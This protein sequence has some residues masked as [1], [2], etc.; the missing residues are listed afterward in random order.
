MGP[1]RGQPL[2]RAGNG[3]VAG[4]RWERSGGGDGVGEGRKEQP[5]PPR[6]PQALEERKG[7]L[8]GVA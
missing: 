5:P 8:V 7:V 6:L 2:R 4:E 3:P 1:G